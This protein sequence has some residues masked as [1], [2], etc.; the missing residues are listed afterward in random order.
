V[1]DYPCQQ[2]NV[3]SKIFVRIRIESFLHQLRSIDLD[4]VNECYLLTGTLMAENLS[5]G[6][7][8]RISNGSMGEGIEEK[9]Q[10]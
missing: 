10:V 8:K 6:I 9:Y 2:S 3:I 5:I 4:E 1:A 7:A